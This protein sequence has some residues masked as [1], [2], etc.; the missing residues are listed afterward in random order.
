MEAVTF[1]HMDIAIQDRHTDHIFFQV[2]GQACDTSFGFNEF[3]VHH[4]GEAIDAG[5]TVANAQHRAELGCVNRCIHLFHTLTEQGGE[6]IR[7]QLRFHK[8]SIFNRL[9]DAPNCGWVGSSK[10][11]GKSLAQTREASFERGI[12]LRIACTHNQTCA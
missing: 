5:N 9:T 11:L 1:T 2:E 12:N 7:L 10:S 3:V 8:Q 4:I 6:F